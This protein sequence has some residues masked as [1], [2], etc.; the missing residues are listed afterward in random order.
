[1]VPILINTDVFELK[2]GLKITVWNCSYF[3]TNLV[4]LF[5]LDT[6][7]R[8]VL[9]SQ[10]NWEE[11]PEFPHLLRVPAHAQPPP[12]ATSSPRMVHLWWLWTCSDISL[13]P[14]DQSVYESPFLV[15]MDILTLSAF[16]GAATPAAPF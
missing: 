10:Q 15:A 6:F 9:G 16:G 11:G 12:L 1:M 13:L 5:T 4:R 8:V 7:F 14:E 2:N 3:C